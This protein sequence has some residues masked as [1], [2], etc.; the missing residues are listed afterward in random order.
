MNENVQKEYNRLNRISRITLITT[1]VAFLVSPFLFSLTI[2][3]GLLNLPGFW[4]GFARV[5]I[6][7][8]PVGIAEFF[9]YAPLL[10]K[11]GT[12]IAFVTGEITGLKIPCVMNARSIANVGDGTM[13]SELVSMMAVTVSSLVTMAVVFVGVIA[14]IPLTPVLSS[15]VLAPAF[16]M[17]IPSLFG[18]LGFKFYKKSLTLASLPL[19]ASTVVCLLAPSMI[20]QTSNLLLPIGAI[21]LV[22]GFFLFKK[23]KLDHM[24]ADA[25]AGM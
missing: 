25:D 14:M 22:F 8:I 18:A 2:D 15:P 4:R 20:A 17:V 23:G 21:A 6:I 16:D 1:T 3:G 11:L 5:A 24:E 7:Y 10:G 13:E 9:I 12:P 19:L